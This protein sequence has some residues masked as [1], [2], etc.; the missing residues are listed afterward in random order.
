VSTTK[1][2]AAALTAMV[3][4][5]VAACAPP[6]GPGSAPACPAVP[7]SAPGPDRQDP[8]SSWGID[9]AG[10]SVVV[11]GGVAYVGGVFQNAVSPT[12][13]KVARQNLAAFCLADGSLLTSFVANFN[14]GPR[15]GSGFEPGGVRALTT[16]GSSL[17]VGGDFTTLNGQPVNRLVK[18]N[19]AT[20][21]PVAGFAPAAIPS[22]VYALDFSGGK[23]YAGGDFSVGDPPAKKGASFDAATGAFAGWNPNADAKINAL[24]VSPDGQHVFIGGSF[25]S[26]GGQAHD[27]LAR[28]S[29]ASGSPDPVSFGQNG[30]VRGRVQAVILSLAVGGD[31]VSA[32]AAAGPTEP[33]G[34]NGGNKAISYAPDGTEIWKVTFDG[35]GQAVLPIGSVLYAGFHDGY[36]G[37]HALKLLGL[38]MS[39]GAV[40][41]FKPTIVGGPLGVR[42]LAAGANRLVAVGDFSS[43]GSTNKLHAVAIFP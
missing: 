39:T 19:P 42:G 37:N 22:V 28:T 5:G 25:T 43:V 1:L 14:N 4:L 8:I 7:A 34:S 24:E 33:R 23:V 10:Y 17:Y 16:D 21:A 41:A 40:T 6:S 26:V 35:D 11:I 2:R 20:G 27:N 13:T 38:D 36:R 32:F 31:N 29:A 18:L 9:G 30:G 15:G 12:G 3:L